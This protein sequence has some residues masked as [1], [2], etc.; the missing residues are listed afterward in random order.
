MDKT[1]HLLKTLAGEAV[2]IQVNGLIYNIH[3]FKMTV[4]KIVQIVKQDESI[5]LYHPC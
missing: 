5:H 2:L 4:I 1:G 3:K